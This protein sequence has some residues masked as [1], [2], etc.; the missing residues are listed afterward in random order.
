MA[1]EC[2][3]KRTHETSFTSALRLETL[4]FMFG[5]LIKLSRSS[6]MDAIDPNGIASITLAGRF[7][8][9]KT[10]TLCLGN[11]SER[12]EVHGITRT[13]RTHRCEILTHAAAVAAVVPSAHNAAVRGA[14][15]VDANA[16]TLL[17]TASKLR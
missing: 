14:R 10:F 5:A 11:P 17:P 16:T 1:E 12:R 3:S 6:S 4:E 13:R 15:E 9:S 7:D 8:V 2:R